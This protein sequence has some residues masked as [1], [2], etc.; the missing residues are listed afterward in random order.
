MRTGF[1]RRLQIPRPTPRSH[2][3]DDVAVRNR[4]AGEEAEAELHE[5][6]LAKAGDGSLDLTQLRHMLEMSV[7]M[8]QRNPKWQNE[9]R[10]PKI[11]IRN[12]RALLAQLQFQ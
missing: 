6:T 1:V 11:V 10:D 12:R 7:A 8:V 4:T 2:A 5:A 9:R 3:A